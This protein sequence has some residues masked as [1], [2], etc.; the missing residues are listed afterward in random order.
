MKCVIMQPFYMP[1]AGLFNLI[2]QAHHFI[3][4]D[5]AQYQKNS[6]HNRNR[7]LINGSPSW[8]SIP[9]K[10]Q[11]GNSLLNTETDSRSKWQ[12]KHPKTI[13]QVYA[14]HPHTHDLE[15]LLNF[16][17]N[18]T[19][20]YLAEVNIESIKLVASKLKLS[21]KFYRSSELNINGNRTERLVNLCRHVSCDEYLSPKGSKEYLLQDGDFKGSG[22]KLLFQD[23]KPTPYTQ[24]GNSGEFISHLSIIDVVANIGWHETSKYIS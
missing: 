5:D 11:F 19:A 2:S 21:P 12:I 3:F 10:H 16:M 6:W 1:W 24:V 8:L 18:T 17:K 9:V 23:F 14:R 7:L 20:I 15:P 22:V 13:S 4:L